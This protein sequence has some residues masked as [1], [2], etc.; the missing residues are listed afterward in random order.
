MA[1][2][3]KNKKKEKEKI[4]HHKWNEELRL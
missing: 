1:P 3:Q 2:Q 4:E